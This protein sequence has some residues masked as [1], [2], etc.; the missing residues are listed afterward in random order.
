MR[1]GGSVTRGADTRNAGLDRDARSDRGNVNRS[2]VS[3]AAGPAWDGTYSSLIP[4][5][6]GDARA[7][8]MARIRPP[9]SLTAK[10]V[11]FIAYT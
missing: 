8:A 4:T 6:I 11:M 5:E 9:A 10:P 1:D 2:A 3:A 7:A